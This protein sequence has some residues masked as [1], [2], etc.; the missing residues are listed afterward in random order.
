MV[1]AIFRRFPAIAAIAA[2]ITAAGCDA[3]VT[4]DGVKGVPLAELDLRGKSPETVVLAGPDAVTVT[5]G[6]A[7]AI[8]VE[9]D[10]AAARA[11]RFSLD[12]DTLTIARERRSRDVEGVARVAVTL[13]RLEEIVLAGSGTLDAPGLTGEGEVTIAGSGTA[14]TAGVDAR[15][16]DVTIAGT[17]TYRADGR[18]ATLDLTVAGTGRADM[19]GLTVDRAEI[20]LAGSGEAQFASD[21]AVE[22]V[23]MGSGTVRV[24]GRARCSVKTMGSGRVICSAADPAAARD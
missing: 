19:A 22:G 17:G 7:L 9:G 15:T 4:V 24:A 20:T 18:A 10:P 13:P 12:D 5:R 14:R 2:G 11:L 8:K 6:E 21:G 1:H 23:V 16:L 3:D